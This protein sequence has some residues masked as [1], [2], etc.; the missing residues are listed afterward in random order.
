MEAEKKRTFLAL[1]KRV[2]SLAAS[3]RGKCF[4]AEGVEVKE[5]DDYVLSCLESKSAANRGVWYSVRFSAESNHFVH[6][7]EQVNFGNERPETLADKIFN[8]VIE[9]Y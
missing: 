3:N 1:M 4:Y 9:R 2:F 7:G 8:K 6:N 5:S